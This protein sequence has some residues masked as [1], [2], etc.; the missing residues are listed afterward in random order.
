MPDR[1]SGFLKV[2]RPNVYCEAC[3][4]RSLAIPIEEV[5]SEVSALEK[6]KAAYTTER[7]ACTM[8]GIVT[9]VIGAN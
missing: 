2:T 1:I 9:W 6:K 5:G 3:L 7:R 8:C 4:S